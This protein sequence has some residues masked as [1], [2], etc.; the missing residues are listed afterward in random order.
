VIVVGYGLTIEQ[1]QW[2]AR[3]PGIDGLLHPGNRTHAAI[4]RLHDLQDAVRRLPADA[5]LAC[6]D[7]GDCLFQARLDPLWRLVAA[8]PGRLLCCGEPTRYPENRA[9]LSW[10]RTI[11]DGAS[12]SRAFE[13]FSTNEWVNAGFVAGTASVLSRYFAAAARIRTEI[14]AGTTDFG[15]QT[16]L[17]Y[18]CHS[19][20]DRWRQIESGWNYCLCSRSPSSYH[21]R[22]DGRFEAANG[23][24]IH[25]VHG[26]ARSLWAVPGLIR[27]RRRIQRMLAPRTGVSWLAHT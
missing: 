3:Q 10:T 2:L 16:A 12:R 5:P 26:N 1:Q 4:R 15:D 11:R 14:L 18:Y 8:N 27:A 9:I 23:E 13:L 19:Q 25:V 6:W 22:S 20:P 21:V 24:P 7:A 17:N